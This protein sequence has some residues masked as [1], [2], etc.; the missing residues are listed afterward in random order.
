MI[1]DNKL[2]LNIRRKI[3]V[4]LDGSDSA[5][6]HW[7]KILDCVKEFLRNLHGDVE[8]EIYFLGNSFRYEGDVDIYANKWRDDNK[9][10]GSFITPVLE[11]IDRNIELI[12]VI[13][14]GRIFDLQDFTDTDF[15]DKLIFVCV[16][17][18]SLKG[19]ERIGKEILSSEINEVYDPIK[20]VIIKGECFMPYFWDNLGYRFELSDEGGLLRG[21]ELEDFSVSICAFGNGI[22]AYCK[23]QTGREVKFDLDEGED[24]KEKWQTLSREDKELFEQIIENKKYKCPLCKKEHDYRRVKCRV[25]RYDISDT[26]IYESLRGTNKGFVIFNKQESNILYRTHSLNVLKL[27][28]NE[29]AVA[30][31]EMRK[32]IFNGKKWVKGEKLENY[33]KIGEEKWIIYF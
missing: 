13:G 33:H 30:I 20:E 4:V 11:N 17:N 22:N 3:A 2:K 28:N 25:N 27:E 31:D 5:K 19:D 7:G 1:Q 12:V 9:N 16:N 29:V 21:S 8:R 18:S 26:C 23:T 24:V 14:S 32:Y 6:K 15:A 10:R